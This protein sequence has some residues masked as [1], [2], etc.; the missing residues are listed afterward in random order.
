MMEVKVRGEGYKIDKL[1]RNIEMDEYDVLYWCR[2]LEEREV[3][4]RDI[5]L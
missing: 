5:S 3:L 2:F 1:R 4:F